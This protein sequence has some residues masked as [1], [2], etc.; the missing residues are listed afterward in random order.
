M[1]ILLAVSTLSAGG[2]ERMASEFVNERAARNDQVA[3][4]TLS[5]SGSDHYALDPR[6]RRIGLDLLWE[7]R[8]LWQTVESNLRRSIMI[9]KSI[10]S[11]E[12]DVVV[13]F[14][15][16]TNIRV[17]ASLLGTGIP[18][19]VSERTDPRHYRVGRSWETARR[20]LYRMA[21]AVV[22]QTE[23]VAGWAAEVVPKHKVRVIPNF[24]RTLPPVPDNQ[25][26]EQLIIGMGRLDRNKGF[27]LLIRSFGAS[28]AG[29]EGW[30]LIILGEGTEREHLEMLIN[31]L[32]L[33]AQVN[34]PGVVAEP[35]EWLAQALI[36]AFPSRLE[37][38]PNAL[39]E[40]MGM[41]C[42]VVA[43]DCP[44][45]PGEIVKHGKDGL[46]VPVDDAFKFTAALDL[47]VE[48]PE[49]AEAL[50]EAAQTV[51]KRF[52]AGRIMGQWDNLIS[53]IAC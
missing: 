53:N 16:Q 46:L 1:R 41:G 35:A 19:I 28:R 51:R 11:F 44:S 5:G 37:G 23:A 38:F 24:V 14:I 8:N 15:E 34:L 50:G 10:H 9:R 27:D 6:V 4:L 18:I 17:L 22:V 30:R 7:S 26:R 20:L 33:T 48:Q 21:C 47:L 29:K 2:S 43:S 45:G 39:L 36:F 52:S 32:G 31:E 42:A 40:A 25:E 12:P 3:L 13:S 49:L